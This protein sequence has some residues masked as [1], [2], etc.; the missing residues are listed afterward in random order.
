MFTLLVR[1]KA[2]DRS[3]ACE[4]VPFLVDTDWIIHSLRGRSDIKAKLEEFAVEG[5]SV[6]I[7]SLAELYEGIYYSFDPARSEAILERFL[8]GL[9][10]LEIDE[11]VARIFGRERGRLRRLR[12]LVGDLDILIGATAMRHNLTLLTNNRR[13][14]ELL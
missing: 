14:F 7:V 4:S 6:S 12:R 3:R 13:D 8:R 2:A 10:G 1:L 5:L 11:E 9:K